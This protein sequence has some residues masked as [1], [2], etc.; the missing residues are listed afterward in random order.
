VIL[1]DE[2]K[3][4]ESNDEFDSWEYSVTNYPNAQDVA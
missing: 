4:T 2:V 1:I 3:K